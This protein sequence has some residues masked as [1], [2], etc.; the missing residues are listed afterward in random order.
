M[1]RAKPRWGFLLGIW[2][3]GISSSATPQS[4][5]Q[6]P[7]AGVTVSGFLVTPDKTTLQSG[8][9]LMNPIV[10]DSLASHP[11]DDVR[12]L[13]DGS[14]SF[15]NVSPGTYQIRARGQTTG[16]GA[17]LFANFRVH[18]GNRDVT[19]LQLVLRRGAVVTGTVEVNS[20]DRPDFNRIRVRAPFVDGTSFGD[21]LT[22][23]VQSGGRFRLDGV[24]E[25]EHYIRLDG[26]PE[27]WVL[28]EA[29]WRG[30]DL[31]DMPFMA[32]SGGT[33]GGVRLV[34]S[35]QANEI[36][37]IVRDH[38]GQPVPYATVVISPA[39]YKTWRGGSPRFVITRSG[40]DGS[41]RHRGLPAGEYRVIAARNLNEA[42]VRAARARALPGVS[43]RF[44]DADTRVLNLEVR[45]GATPQL[46][47]AR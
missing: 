22:G 35:T 9:V 36:R 6:A 34:V 3:V 30:T 45:S 25:G 2:L 1:R 7:A 4:T 19:G 18:V 10:G 39:S 47:A 17:T 32:T 16:G 21:A 26:L 42:D 5:S 27:P 44:G 41:Y 37:G 29:H 20:D 15:Q 40:D 14:F 33:I 43:V 23:V 46:P 38:A 24:M 11:P 13:P 31:A 28:K 8:A 12:F